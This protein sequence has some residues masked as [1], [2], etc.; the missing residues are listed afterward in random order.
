MMNQPQLLNSDDIAA[1]NVSDL[2]IEDDN[3]VD[4]FQSAKQQ[5]LLVEPLYATWSPGIPFIADANIGLFFALKQA[6]IVSDAFLSLGVQMPADWSQKQNRSYFVWEFGKVPDV[7]IEIVS[8]QEGNELGSKKA[9]YA[10]IGVPYYAIFDPLQQ[11]QKPDELNGAL[12]KVFALNAGRYLDLDATAGNIPCFWLT[13]VD[14]GLALWEGE[15]EGH[16]GFWLRWCTQN[17]QVIPTGREQAEQEK[18]RAEQEKQ[19][20]DRLAQHLRSLGI[21][22]DAV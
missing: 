7:C 16:P 2:V 18:Q 13:T 19:R 15:F 10:R 20:A 4:N 14:V 3:P 21:D 5:R 8:N 17:G 11:L 12:L 9:T 22:P 6:P 1:L